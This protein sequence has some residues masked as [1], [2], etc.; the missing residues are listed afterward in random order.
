MKTRIALTFFLLAAQSRGRR[1]I[2]HFS[3][4]AGRIAY[5]LI[6]AGR[7]VTYARQAWVV[8][9]ESLSQPAFGREC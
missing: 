8:N 2:A 4:H 6:A 9:R 5:Q 1:C 7:G 3:Y